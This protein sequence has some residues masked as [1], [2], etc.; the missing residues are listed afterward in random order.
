[1]VQG[2]EV[3]QWYLRLSRQCDIGM[4]M[5]GLYQVF[6]DNHIPWDTINTGYLDKFYDVFVNS[7]GAAACNLEEAEIDLEN[8]KRK[9]DMD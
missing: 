6:Q 5:G 8:L 2:E 7:E 1:M 4:V 9:S 3:K